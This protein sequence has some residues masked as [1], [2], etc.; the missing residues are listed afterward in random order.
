VILVF[1][2]M[3]QISIQRRFYTNTNYIYEITG[4]DSIIYAATNGGAVAYDYLKCVFQVL[5]NTDG[6]QKNQQ[7]CIA[8]DS[9]GHIWVGNDF[10]LAQIDKDFDDVQTYPVEYLTGTIIKDVLIRDDSIYVASPSGLTFIEMNGTPTDFTDDNRTRIFDINVRSIT[11]SDTFIWVGT[12]DGLWRYNKDF[13]VKM[14]Y[15]ISDGLLT[16]SINQ[17]AIID[18]TV[19]VATDYGLNS[20]QNDHF[21][22]LL[23]NHYIKDISFLGDSLALALDSVSLVGLFYQG[24]LTLISSG[25]PT[26]CSLQSLLNIDGMLFCGLGSRSG[27]DYHG[28]GIGDYNPDSNSWCITKNRCLP[29]NH[30]SC[31]SANENGMFVACG[32]RSYASKGIGWL[33]DDGEWVNFAKDSIISSNHIHR[34]VTAPD[35]KIWFAINSLHGDTAIVYSFN[36]YRNEWS[37]IR[38]GYQG[39]DTT[40]AIWDM[41]FDDHNNMYLDFAGPSDKLWIIDSSLTTASFLGE[42]QTGFD[43]EIAI[44]SSGRVWRTVT[45]ADGGLLMIDTKNT[46]FDRSDD[47]SYKYGESDGLLSKYASGCV[48]G[49]NGNLYVANEIG[50][51]IYDGLNFSGITGIS[52]DELLDVEL[53]SEGRVWIMARDGVYYYDPEFHITDGYSFNELNLHVEFL[54][55]SNEVIQIQG[56]EFDTL[57]GCFW[58]GGENGLLQLKVE[59]DTLPEL[60]SAL[61]FPNP[62]VGKNR[63]KIRNIPSDSRINIYA[64]SGRLVAENL[65]PNRTFGEVVWEIPDDIGSGLYF[66]LIRSGKGNKVCK[67]AIIK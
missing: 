66:A 61:I 51:V 55:L 40:V 44:D 33:R 12:D 64:I 27:R 3:S 49:R 20:F 53:D 13:V 65:L 10:G 39:M 36:P 37:S 67:F 32:S 56:F 29:S 25:I 16:N 24:N 23:L 60:D 57:R 62:V 7:N 58:L 8:L 22:T 6:L 1:F 47:Y 50:L 43:I 35:N 11:V 59:F 19:Y 34:C 5:T 63:V 14:R 31:I 2:L 15:D 46:L 17:V 42:R 38:P 26:R 41:K 4:K 18:G 28:E 30:I 45:G 9:S 54:E 21:D 48:V 52:N